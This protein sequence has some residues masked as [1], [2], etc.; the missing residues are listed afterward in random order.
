M[1]KKPA[2][3]WYPGDWRKDPM[4]DGLSTVSRG[5]WREL[6]DAIY[7]SPEKYKVSGTVEGLARMARCSV[8]ELQQFLEENSIYKVA[9]VTVC[10]E[11]VTVLCRRCYREEK[12]RERV[13]NAVRKKREKE[14]ETELLRKCNDVSSFS[15]NN[16]Y[17]VTTTTGGAYSNKCGEQE[18]DK[19]TSA[20]GI[21]IPEEGKVIQAWQSYDPNANQFDLQAIDKLYHW[22]RGYFQE[23]DIELDPVDCMLDSIETLRKKKPP[24]DRP[25]SYLR[26][27][28][29]KELEAIG[30]GLDK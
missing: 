20:L 19:T 11:I 21:K 4:V 27:I 28:I 13:R 8:E 2:Y 25:I 18:E 24:P 23:H 26:G 12:E 16:I 5:V 6:I 17:N 15:Y 9:D 3:L 7:L 22:L 29:G 14:K 30:H 1:G 10:N